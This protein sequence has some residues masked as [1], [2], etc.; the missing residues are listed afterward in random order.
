[1]GEQRTDPAFRLEQDFFVKLRARL[2]EERDRANERHRSITAWL[3]RSL[4]PPPGMRVQEVRTVNIL[5]PPET[6]PSV[7]QLSD[8]VQTTFWASLEREEGRPLRFTVNFMP[9]EPGSE[10]L[11]AFDEPL[12]YQG[13]ELTK[14]APAVGEGRGTLFVAPFERE[15]LK[16]W[17]L[18]ARA[19]APVSVKAI[20]PGSIIVKFEKTNVAAV[21][22]AEALLIR[23]PHLTLNSVIWSRFAPDRNEAVYDA[24]ADARRNAILETVKRMRSLGHGG[25]LIVV[26]DGSQWQESIRTPI[27]YSGSVSFNPFREA[28][29]RLRELREKG[30]HTWADEMYWWTT[31]VEASRVLSRLT[32]VDGATIVTYD[33]SVIGFG[34][35][36][37]PARGSAGPPEVL[38]ID[39][40][41][42]D[43]WFGSMTLEQLG[44]TRHQSAARFVSEQKGAI[45]FVVSQ[46]GEVTAI[47]WYESGPGY[48]PSLYA[49]RRL[50]LTLF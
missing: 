39:P 3:K 40:L 14:L 41:D 15:G 13:R 26:P 47:V 48:R 11:V 42:H 6:I 5:H 20:D 10:E 30:G 8:L 2:E 27:T 23:D 28:V 24:W 1:V 18:G 9:P 50:E 17:G 37:Q 49:H 25:T 32:A 35:K 44:G 7:E 31:M 29:R 4:V 46:D 33:L 36:L 22:R 45:A 34:A 43:G 12:P 16:I 38:N 19:S 21:S